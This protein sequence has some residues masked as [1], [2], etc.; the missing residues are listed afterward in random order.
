MH[1]FGQLLSNSLSTT[2]GI[3]IADNANQGDNALVDEQWDDHQNCGLFELQLFIGIVEDCA[4]Q[5]SVEK[6]EN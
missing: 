2:G 4:D 6:V 5:E 1:G 3:R